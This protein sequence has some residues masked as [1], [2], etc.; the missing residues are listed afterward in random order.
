MTN[1]FPEMF[2]DNNGSRINQNEELSFAPAEG[3]R[4][5]S[6]LQED[7]W[8]IK[9]WP[10]LHPDGQFGLHHKR[11]VRLTE[12]QYFAQRILNQDPRFSKSPSYIFAAAAYI[13]QK[14]LSNKANISYM[15]GK[16]ATINGITEYD[17]DDDFTVF[18]GIKNTPKY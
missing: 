16:K 9:S 5:T 10:N 17:L 18:E 4:P 12:Q 2:I 14:Q 13:E 11:K 7:D 6:L 3:N 8:D 1:N 15:R